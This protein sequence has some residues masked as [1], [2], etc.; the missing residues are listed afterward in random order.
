M[1]RLSLETMSIVHA[2]LPQ[3]EA[4]QAALTLRMWHHLSEAPDREALFVAFS[5]DGE[6][7]LLQSFLAAVKQRVRSRWP[8]LKPSA[9]LCEAH[10]PMLEQAFRL[11]LGDLMGARGNP[12]MLNAWTQTFHDFWV[13][14]CQRSTP[15]TQ[16]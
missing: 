12:V 10:G 16:G 13:E 1:S 7:S 5:G 8:R 2:M 11:A 14:M 4:Q 9:G 15:P 3:V 6:Q